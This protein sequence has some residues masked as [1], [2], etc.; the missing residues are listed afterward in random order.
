VADPTNPGLG[1]ATYKEYGCK[2][3]LRIMAF[4]WT[5]QEPIQTQAQRLGLTWQLLSSEYDMNADSVPDPI[6]TLD[7]APW[8]F[9]S[10]GISYHP[11]YAM[12]TLPVESYCMLSYCPDT[13][14]TRG[15]YHI[16]VTDLDQN[17]QPEILVTFQ[18]GLVLMEWIG[19]RFQRHG[20]SFG[21]MEPWT[22]ETIPY[23]NEI[24]QY[25]GIRVRLDGEVVVRD[26]TIHATF[27]GGEPTCGLRDGAITCTG[28][29]PIGPSEQAVLSAILATLFRD[30]EP[31]RALEAL[32]GYTTDDVWRQ[33]L[34][35][36]LRALTLEYVGEQAQA[37]A[38]FDGIIREFPGSGWA[39]L[40]ESRRE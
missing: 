21:Y 29:T 18:T 38:A 25:Q 31:Q 12:Q 23:E 11:L 14:E 3:S 39:Q 19:Y 37:Q 33:G 36:Y 15:E 10:D 32:E 16:Y 2:P 34:A 28:T 30:R 1:G 8:V 35:E 24:W 40:A 22:N 7:N 5:S 27:P 4:N 13:I 9:L 6:G 26:N 20:V 17:S